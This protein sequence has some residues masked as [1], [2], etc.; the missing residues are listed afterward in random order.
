MTRRSLVLFVALL[1]AAAPAAVKLCDA[2]CSADGDVE[3]RAHH[4]GSFATFPRGPAADGTLTDRS[5]QVCGVVQAVLS[6]SR[7]IVQLP[8][9][10]PAVRSIDAIPSAARTADPLVLDSHAPPGRVPALAPLRI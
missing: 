6:D 3:H 2:L 10:G 8:A 4:H 7:Q 5:P 1:V 9:A